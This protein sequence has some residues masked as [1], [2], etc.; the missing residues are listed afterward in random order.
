MTVNLII[1]PEVEQ[2]IAEAYAWY[3]IQRTGLGEEFL[4]C[5]DAL[6]QAIVRMPNINAIVF[7]AYRRG[8]SG[9]FF[10]NGVFDSV[11]HLKKNLL[12]MINWITYLRKHNHRLRKTK[13]FPAATKT[14]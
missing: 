8:W 2:D 13:L 4:S 11:K 3:E 10:K 6:I 12:H 9:V 1:A 7:H 14:L 5:V